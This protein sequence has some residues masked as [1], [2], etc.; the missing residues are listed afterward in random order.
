MPITQTELSTQLEQLI[1]SSSLRQV[2]E[3]I[4]AIASE[5]AFHIGASYDDRTLQKTW[6]NASKKIAHTL[7]YIG[8]I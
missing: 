8:E 1:D 4:S 3:T 2:L 5:K 6:D 7:N